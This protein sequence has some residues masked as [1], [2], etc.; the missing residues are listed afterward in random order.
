M[1]KIF[2]P[3]L[4]MAVLWGCT[5]APEP[6]PI[7]KL[8]WFT[9]SA[10]SVEYLNGQVKSID[11]IAYWA[12]EENGEIV[13]GAPMTVKDLDSIGWI[14]NV[15]LMFNEEGLVTDSKQLNDEGKA[16]DYDEI[17][18]ENGK[19]MKVTSV[20]KDTARS[21]MIFSHDAAGN[22]VHMEQFRLPED[23][24]MNSYD[25]KFDENGN[26]MG[27]QWSNYLG[28]SGWSHNFVYNEDNLVTLRE[29]F[30][31]EGE[32]AGSHEYTYD[33]IGFNLSWINTRSD[34]TFLDLTFKYPKVDDKGNW[35]E[36]V[37][38]ENGKVSGMDVRTIEYY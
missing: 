1:K 30:N 20:G 18:I 19:Y 27:G 2:L 14:N 5:T 6:E 24:L 36:M 9:N 31:T 15:A 28:E 7:T 21:Y 22:F 13:R 23:T 33:E 3:I 11:Q 4:C 37:S 32:K 8:G 25:F 34:T 10:W 16:L 26:W 12:S 29:N 38:F 35:L 17:I